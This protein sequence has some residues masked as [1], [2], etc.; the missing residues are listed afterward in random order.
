MALKKYVPAS[1]DAL[2]AAKINPTNWKA[3][4]RH[5][6]S[7]LEMVP[8]RFRTKQAITSLETCAKCPTLPADKV[9]EVQEK[10]NYANARLAKQDAEVGCS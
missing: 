10:L 4:W 3:H 2:Q 9:R 7:L 1:H 8:K 5:A 6:I